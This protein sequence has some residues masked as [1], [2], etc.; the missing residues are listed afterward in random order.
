METYSELVMMNEH[1]IEHFIKF[2]VVVHQPYVRR[3]RTRQEPVG[4][5]F[6]LGISYQSDNSRQLLAAAI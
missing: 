5:G 6:N 4:A 2:L 1:S 3:H